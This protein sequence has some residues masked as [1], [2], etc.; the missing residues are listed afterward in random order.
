MNVIYKYPIE[1]TGH[2]IIKLPRA[3][4]LLHVGLDPNGTPCLWAKINKNMP[5]EDKPIYIF[6]TGHVIP[7]ELNIQHIGSFVQTPFVWHVFTNR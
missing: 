2:Q 1:I 5:E 4:V 6:G 3:A 7:K